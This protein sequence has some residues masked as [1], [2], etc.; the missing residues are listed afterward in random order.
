MINSAE[1]VGMGT[2]GLKFEKLGSGGIYKKLY[3]SY[4]FNQD[5]SGRL[6][7]MVMAAETD[8]TSVYNQFDHFSKQDVVDLFELPGR[9]LYLGRIG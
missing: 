1:S 3:K 6:Y 7:L 5:N 2:P 8:N 4:I 9:P